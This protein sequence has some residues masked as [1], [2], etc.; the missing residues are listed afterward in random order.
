MIDNRFFKKHHKRIVNEAII[1]SALCG[2]AI[3]FAIDFLL[4]LASWLF[5]FGNM[6]IALGAGLG[7]A[8]LAGV[9]FYFFKFRPTPQ[10]IARRIDR[11]GLEERLTTM[12][13]LQNDDSYI[14][15][16]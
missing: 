12:M 5:A 8:A 2:L 1:K 15:S 4:A 16:V 11:L 6:W 13:E 10:Y 9:L 14:A 3:G 7:S